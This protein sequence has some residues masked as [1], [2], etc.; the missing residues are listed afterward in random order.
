AIVNKFQNKA[1]EDYTS[2]MTSAFSEMYRILKP[3]RWITIV[4]HNSKASVW[5]AI[6]ESVVRSGFIIAQVTTLDKKQGSFKQVTSAGAVKNDLIIN[7]YKPKEDFSN[8]FIKNAGKEMEI[9]FVKEQLNHLPV[10]PNIE[11]TE[12]M[13]Y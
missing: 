2:L 7:A 13:L 12:T 5:N 10:K 6:Q 4:F 1:L 11:R 9:D 8:R 3:N